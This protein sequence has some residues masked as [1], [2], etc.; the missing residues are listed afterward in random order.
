MVVGIGTGY[1]EGNGRRDDSFL[2]ERGR[3]DKV[4]I[5]LVE[6]G[7]FEGGTNAS[8]TV[9]EWTDLYEDFGRNVGFSPTFISGD[10]IKGMVWGHPT[11]CDNLPVNKLCL[12]IK[13][14]CG[15]CYKHV[16]CGWCTGR[17]G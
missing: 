5:R 15:G 6:G 9:N 17:L 2:E 1:H 13:L 14:F 16:K 8:V 7:L 3:Y 10:F 4:I 12:R 11:D